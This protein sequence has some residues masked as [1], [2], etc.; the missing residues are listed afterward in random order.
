[1]AGVTEGQL[2]LDSIDF[3]LNN[4]SSQMSLVAIG[5]DNTMEALQTQT[6]GNLCLAAEGLWSYRG[7]TS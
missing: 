2:K 5:M 6:K 1:M 3:N 4:L 7:Q